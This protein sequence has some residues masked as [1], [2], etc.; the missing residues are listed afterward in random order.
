MCHLACLL[1]CV[2]LVNYVH[3]YTPTHSYFIHLNV[4][5]PSY[6]HRKY[7]VTVHLV[8]MS[9]VPL[10]C[11]ILIPVNLLFSMFG[12]MLMELCCSCDSCLTK[13]GDTDGEGKIHFF[14]VYDV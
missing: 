8:C 7:L 6:T 1:R 12:R 3:K 11:F 2:P 10:E 5:T 13:W 9:S 4:E 14:V